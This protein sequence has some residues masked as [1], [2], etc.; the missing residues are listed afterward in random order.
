MKIL[1]INPHGIGDVLFSLPLLRNLKDSVNPVS[2]G[3]I[4]NARVFP[5]LRAQQEVDFLYCYEKDAWRAKFKSSKIKALGEFKS[6]LNEIKKEKFDIVFDLS[7]AQEFGFFCWFLGI[8]KRF[9]YDYKKRGLFL[10]KK[11]KLQGYSDKHVVEYYNDLLKLI[12]LTPRCKNYKLHLPTEL[13]EE[14]EAKTSGL[15]SRHNIIIALIPGGGAS[16]GKDAYKKRW[17]DEKYKR[18]LKLLKE[19]IHAGVI[20]L[21]DLSDMAAFKDVASDSSV[22]NFMGRTDILEFAGLISKADMVLT[23]DGGPL[24]IAVALGI[25][26]VSIF[27]PVP[28]SV[29][30]PYP[31]SNMH[32]VLKSHVACRPCYKGF[33]IS[34]CTDY[35]CLSNISV[36]FVFEE[37][38]KHLATI[39]S[40]V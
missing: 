24:H 4:C 13:L 9:G 16:W 25:P 26:S 36:D 22:L 12:D 15:K 30:G 32:K 39:L 21:G 1:I 34:D 29:Y 31:H 6:F 17:K 8:K 37:V 28:E 23:N 7:L 5:L 3:Y 19:D 11:I 20:L 10:N 2:I 38:K 18:L 14:A 27:G 40:G 35:K 33:R